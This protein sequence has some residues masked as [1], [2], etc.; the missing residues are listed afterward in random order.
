M[1]VTARDVYGDLGPAYNGVVHF[2]STDPATVLPAD[3]AL[4]N[5]VGTFY[6]K[7]MAEGAQTL[8]VN[9]VATPSI[10]GSETL[11]GTPADVGSF[12][13]TGFPSTTAGVAQ[14]FTVT[15]TDKVGKLDTRYTGTVFFG[16]SDRRAGLPAS[17]TF[18]AADSGVHTLTATLLTAGPQTITASDSA[19][20]A[21]GVQAGNWVAPA[22]AASFSVTG[23]VT[24][25]AGVS[26][27]VTLI[28]RDAYGNRRPTTRA[29]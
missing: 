27:P 10:T 4:V 5:G 20:G 16:S 6:V 22:V 23:P 25:T 11:S 8:T 13:I 18:T 26:N 15:A 7:M 9:D 12:A 24:A 3:A 14:S 19:G 17:Y 1:S 2:A 28:V 29:R 21:F